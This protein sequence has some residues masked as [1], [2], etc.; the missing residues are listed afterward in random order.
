MHSEWFFFFKSTFRFNLA[1]LCKIFWKNLKKSLV[2]CQEKFCYAPAF[3]FKAFRIPGCLRQH[4]SIP[5]TTKSLNENTNSISSVLF[6]SNLE[7]HI[8]A[9]WLN[10]LS[11]T[12]LLNFSQSSWVVQQFSR[13]LCIKQCWVSQGGRLLTKTER[14]KENKLKWRNTLPYSREGRG[15]GKGGG[16]N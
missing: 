2:P 4:L 11:C 6:S 3:P 12:L 7:S 16:L 5:S 13:L 10:A 14:Q 8:N 1:A 9:T 15:K